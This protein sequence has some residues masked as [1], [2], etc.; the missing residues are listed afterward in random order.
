MKV[1]SMVLYTN[2]FC[3]NYISQNIHILLIVLLGYFIINLCLYV[4]K[5][6]FGFSV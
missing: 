3:L 6:L 5:V 2:A 1:E 4:H